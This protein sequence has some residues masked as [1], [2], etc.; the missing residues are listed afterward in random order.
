MMTLTAGRA[1]GDGG[2]ERGREE[3]VVKR[4]RAHIL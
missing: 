2:T 4:E 3:E 1:E